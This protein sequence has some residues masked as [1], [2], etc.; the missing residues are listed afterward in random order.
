MVELQVCQS[1]VVDSLSRTPVVTSSKTHTASF[2]ELCSIDKMQYFYKIATCI[3]Q[4]PNTD[5]IKDVQLD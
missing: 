2:I 3:S 4:L 1:V 5:K